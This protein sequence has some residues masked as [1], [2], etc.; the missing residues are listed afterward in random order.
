MQLVPR[1]LNYTLSLE[2]Y[3]R[4]LVAATSMES[5]LFHSPRRRIALLD[6]CADFLGTLSSPKQ[7]TFQWGQCPLGL[8]A[9][10]LPVNRHK[11]ASTYYL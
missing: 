9:L 10:L 8:L 3:S 1:T 5:N 2:I 11:A 4:I 7:D 6:I